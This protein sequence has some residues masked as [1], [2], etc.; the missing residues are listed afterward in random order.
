MIPRKRRNGKR[1]QPSVD[2]FARDRGDHLAVEFLGEYAQAAAN[3]AQMPLRNAVCL[4]R[5][6]EVFDKLR[7]CA[8]LL[9]RFQ[10]GDV[11]PNCVR[12]GLP[13]GRNC[14]TAFCAMTRSSSRKLRVLDAVALALGVL[15][16]GERIGRVFVS[17][18]VRLRF[19]ASR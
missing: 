10:I 9:A 13:N 15:E 7:R 2:F 18:N 3:V 12:D 4:L 5:F 19:P 14:S 17:K 6:D 16:C 11:M 1:A 8:R